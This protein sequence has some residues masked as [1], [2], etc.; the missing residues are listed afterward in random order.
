MHPYFLGRMEMKFAIKHQSI[1]RLRVQLQHQRMSVQQADQLQGFLA[2]QLPFCVVVVHERT[3]NIIFHH[4]QNK[5]A[6]VDCLKCLRWQDCLESEQAKPGLRALSRE[7]EDRLVAKV[8]V[9]LLTS[10]YL[11]MP[12]QIARTLFH[13]LPILYKGLKAL[14]QRQMKVELLDAVSLGASLVTRDFKTASELVFLLELGELLEEWTHKKSI[15]DLADSMSLHVDQVWVRQENQDVLIPIKDVKIKDQLVLR[16]G[17]VIPVD[18][19]VL[20]GQAMVNQASMTGEGLAVNKEMGGLVYAGTTIEQGALV[21]EVSQPYGEGRYDQIVHMIEQ[22]Q[23]RQSLIEGQAMA[24]ADR[25]VPYTLAGSG[26]TYLLT[27]NLTKAL[28]VLMVDFSCA[29][30]LAMPLAVMSAMRQASYQHIRVKGGKYL[31]LFAQADTIVFDKT[32]TL[33]HAHPKVVDVIAL[34]GMSA[35]EMLRMAACLEEHFPHSMAN[36][37]VEAAKEKGLE[38][39]EFHSEVEYIVAH[40]IV[41][42]VAGKRVLIGSAHF[43]FE[44]EGIAYPDELDQLDIDTS[45]SRLYMAMGEVLVAII[46]IADPLR[47]EA[48]TV[49]AGLKEAGFKRLVMMTGDNKL[50][51]ARVASELGI[52]EYFGEVLPEDKAHYVTEL[53]KQGHTVVMVGDGINDSPALSEADVGIAIRDGAAIASDIAD[54]TM[55][56]HRLDELLLLRQLSSAMMKRFNETYRFVMGFNGSLMALG[57]VGLLSPST[58]SLLHN[59]STLAISMRNMKLYELDKKDKTA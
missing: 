12:V 8:G 17:D 20:E 51:A 3:G 22:S 34:A 43:I 35:D 58:A 14:W 56:A 55:A 13:A 5:D 29:L 21:I 32:G 47:Q 1:H 28:S 2:K 4:D 42:H 25:L 10:L 38:H 7:Y 23:S 18:G 19:C 54:I 57:I 44:D 27:R 46:C 26:L 37:V 49:L 39:D 15:Q 36:A 33:T 41:S 45:Y 11:P 59:G 53:K 9:K 48:K 6:I 24:L 31:E 52:D 30:K 40:G 50:T 16:V